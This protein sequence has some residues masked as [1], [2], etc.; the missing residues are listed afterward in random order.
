MS[1]EC[2]IVHETVCVA[3]AVSLGFSVPLPAVWGRYGAQF[4]ASRMRPV[5]L[6]PSQC[7][8][9]AVTCGPALPGEWETGARCAAS[10][11]FIYNVQRNTTGG[12]VSSKE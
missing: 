2:V 3:C 8:P 7:P 12:G 11:L 10:F 5:T 6:A 4:G 9:G 1:Y